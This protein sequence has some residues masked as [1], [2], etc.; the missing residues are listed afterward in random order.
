MFYP[1]NL[2][3]F[4]G[5][6][7]ARIDPFEPF[8]IFNIIKPLLG[9]LVYFS[10]GSKTTNRKYKS[11]K[12]QSSLL[13][14]DM[15]ADGPNECVISFIANDTG[16]H[17]VYFDGK[18]V[19]RQRCTP[20]CGIFERAFVFNTLSFKSFNAWRKELVAK[21]CGVKLQPYWKVRIS[22]AEVLHHSF[23]LKIRYA[24]R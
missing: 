12:K 19:L 2:K 10:K 23:W 20:T 7:N 24:S 1:S 16:R 9:L 3:L 18:H 14:I 22:Y 11:I 15:K 6:K 13:I 17:V 5:Q 8:Q 21:N 4:C